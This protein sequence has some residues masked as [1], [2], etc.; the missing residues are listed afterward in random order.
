MKKLL[1]I[2]LAVAL[3]ATVC[4]IGVSAAEDP[5]PVDGTMDFSLLPD[6]ADDFKVVKAGVA[7]DEGTVTITKDGDS[8]VFKGDKGWPYAYNTGAVTQSAEW[9]SVILTEDVFLNFDFQVKSGN[10]KVIVYYCG[11]N[12]EDM[13][14]IGNYIDLNSVILKEYDG[15]KGG[16]DSDVGVGHYKGSVN[17]STLYGDDI[18]YLKDMFINPELVVD[19]LTFIS[20]FKVFAVAGAEVIV[21]DI[22]IGKEK[23]GEAKA[24]INE[25]NLLTNG[26]TNGANGESEVTFKDGVYEVKVNTAFDGTNAYGMQVAAGLKDFD[27]G[28]T[29]NLHIAIDSDTPWRLTTRDGEI[30][31]WFGL[32]ANFGDCNGQASAPDGDGFY[33]AGKYEIC[34]DY[35]S[36]YVWNANQGGDASF[37]V[38]SAS[39]DGIYIEGKDAGT[40]KISTLKLSAAVAFTATPG[41]NTGEGATNDDV[42]TEDAGNTTK[43]A[44][45]G[46]DA[47]TTAKKTTTTAKKTGTDDKADNVETGDVSSAVLFAVIAVIALAV[48]ALSAKVKAR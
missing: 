28:A 2:V 19:D 46:N 27:L 20:G 44:D 1:S 40:M 12:P 14:A 47:T 42:N 35:G 26:A 7:G 16:T 22:S 38:K 15:T 13:A 29:T 48:V 8:F 31:K 25:L 21:N 4:C 5:T 39:L 36:I 6:S 17:L 37:D 32:A 41:T 18:D 10:S 30:D 24:E 34:V 3:L 9:A 11:Q 33:P 23:Y 43:P 45:S